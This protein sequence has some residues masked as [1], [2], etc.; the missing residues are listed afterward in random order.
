MK[1]EKGF[2]LIELIVAV[3]ILVVIGGTAYTAFNMA[4]DVYHR[5]AMRMIMIQDVRV[6][7]NSVARDLSNVYLVEGDNTLKVLTEDVP[8][9]ETVSHDIISFVA[10][11]NTKIDPFVSQLSLTSEEEEEEDEEEEE[12]PESNIKRILYYLK[13][14]EPEEEEEL[15]EPQ[16]FETELEEPAYSLIRATSE[17]LDLG[18]EVSL[19]E[20]IESGVIPPTTDEELEEGLEGTPLEEVVIAE[21]VTSLDF[22]Y[23]D[24]EEWLDDWEEEESPPKAI[25]VIITVVDERGREKPATQSTMVYLTLSANFSEEAEGAQGAGGGAPGGTGGGGGAPGGPGGGGGGR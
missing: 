15:E 12:L 1:I 7:T 3:T 4:L 17:K 6:A 18:E 25:Q 23:S 8:E 14:V 9:D 2:T 5:D 16:V 10:I 24:G 22:K 19:Q 13:T 11:V 21:N 20:I